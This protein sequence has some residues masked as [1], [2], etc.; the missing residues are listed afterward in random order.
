MIEEVII[1]ALSYVLAGY[2]SAASANKIQNERL[3]WRGQGFS[4][5]ESTGG[6]HFVISVPHPAHPL[7]SSRKMTTSPLWEAEVSLS[8]QVFFL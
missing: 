2:F 5:P 8:I 6:A 7:V 1:A 3:G 4:L